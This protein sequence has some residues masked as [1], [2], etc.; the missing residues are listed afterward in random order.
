M[1]MTLD[2][3][4]TYPDLEPQDEEQAHRLIWQLIEG[5][6][7]SVARRKPIR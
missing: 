3:P 1:A 7:G 2:R 6:R 4:I 5:E